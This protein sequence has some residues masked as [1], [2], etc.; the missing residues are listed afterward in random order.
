MGIQSGLAL[1]PTLLIEISCGALYGFLSLPLL[2]RAPYGI[3]VSN[4][5]LDRVVPCTHFLVAY[6]S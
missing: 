2:K 3:L 1:R 4:F 5:V 6:A